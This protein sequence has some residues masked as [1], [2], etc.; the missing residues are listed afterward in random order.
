MISA[1]LAASAFV[2]SGIVR[3]TYPFGP[4]S[5]NTN[6][7]GQQF[8]PF[9][10]HLRDILTGQAPGDLLINWNSGFGIPFLGDFMAYMGASLSWIVLLFPRDKPDLALFVI[11][12]TAIAVAVGGDDGVLA[13]ASPVRSGLAGDRGRSLVRHVWLGDRRRGVYDGVVERPDR[14]PGDLSVV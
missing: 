2:V 3:N 12:T 8:I 7:L 1:L 9:H 6:D 13:A 4:V 10:A 5:R 14:V 11:A